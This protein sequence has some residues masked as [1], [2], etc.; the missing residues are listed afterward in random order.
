MRLLVYLLFGTGILLD[1]LLLVAALRGKLAAFP[2]PPSPINRRPAS[3]SDVALA[4]GATLALALP[5]AWTAG[6]AA[7]APT[8]Q[9]LVLNGIL[10]L[11]I[12]GGTIAWITR[13]SPARLRAYYWSPDVPF[14]R[15]IGTG[16]VLGIAVVPVLA[17]ATWLCETA[18]EALGLPADPQPVF[19]WLKSLHSFK[20]WAVMA[21]LVLILA[22][23]MEE[24][25]FRGIL[26]P[27]A[28]SR[29]A[30]PVMPVLLVGFYFAI[31]HVHAPSLLPL[32]LLSACFSGGY[33][34]TGCILTPVIMHAIFNASSLLCFAAGF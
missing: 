13:L 1:V 10:V 17:L 34:L 15:V 14:R 24:G 31:V 11:G 2:K 16:A 25:L 12:E 23:L 22:P 32:I 20:N 33:A 29:R 8:L 21:G 18:C 19:E 5:A 30:S 28:L 3:P 4:L 6:G 26:L 9:L 7:A 27:A